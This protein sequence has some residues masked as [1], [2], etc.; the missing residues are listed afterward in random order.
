MLMR[1][2]SFKSGSGS[3]DG[4]TGTVPTR[5]LKR[6]PF[7]E[8][9]KYPRNLGRCARGLHPGP[10]IDARLHRVSRS[11]HH[12]AGFALA[13]AAVASHQHHHDHGAA[14]PT[15]NLA[16]ALALLAGLMVVEV[17]AGVLASSLALL[18]DAAHML[19]D[20]G[21][22]ALAL[23]AA[24][25]ARRPAGGPMTYGYQRV[26]VLSA[27]FNGATL[28]VLGLLIVYEG[29]RRLVHPPPV[30]GATVL[31]VA[32][33]G[34]AV[35]LAATWTLRRGESRSLNVEGALAHIVTD[36]AAFALTALAG[37]VILVTGARRADGIAS[38]VIAAIMLRAAVS[39]LRASGRVFLEAAPP[40]VDPRDI[41]R[42]MASQT[43]VAEVHD[44][45]VWEVS[46]GFPALSAHVIVGPDRDCHVARRELAAMLG[47]RFG[48]DH[49]TLQ[50]EHRDSPL[51]H[52]ELPGSELP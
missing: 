51:L 33:A 23:V 44:L 52:L 42:A 12:D 7:G 5:A 18:S 30:A 39:L 2:G 36:L 43:G 50:V 11:I 38:L 31:V 45:H 47:E 24:R 13:F 10:A 15:R 8:V 17:L 20:A 3:G 32:L 49:T 34:V 25:I 41:G 28:L 14:A 9:G 19:T 16:I 4:S 40:G 6:G 27:Q 37:V 48:I 22:L 46:S 26:E 21:A 35:N 29:V 1:G